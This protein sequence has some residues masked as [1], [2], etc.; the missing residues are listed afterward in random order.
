MTLN[1]RVQAWILCRFAEIFQ[2][3]LRHEK[4]QTVAM[5]DKGLQTETDWLGNFFG[6]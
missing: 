5:P 4:C 3:I 1:K 2:H 6:F